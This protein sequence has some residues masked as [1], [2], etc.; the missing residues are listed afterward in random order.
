V[1]DGQWNAS[2]LVWRVYREPLQFPGDLGAC[3]GE[4]VMR[5]RTQKASDWN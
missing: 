5:V 2:K 4:Y 3:D 1:P